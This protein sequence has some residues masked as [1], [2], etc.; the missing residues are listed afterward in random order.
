MHSDFITLFLAQVNISILPVILLPV[1]GLSCLLFYNRLG[2]IVV[3]IQ[4]LER[5][6]RIGL[7]QSDTNPKNKEEQA[8]LYAAYHVLLKRSHMIRMA[9][10]MCFIA[11]FLFAITALTVIATVLIPTAVLVTLGLWM[12]GALCYATAIVYAFKEIQKPALHTLHFQ[13]ELIEKWMNPL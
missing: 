7:K 9:I 1:T 3:S 11:L 10:K 4:T 6:L 13:T 5:E 12:I 2:G 8:A